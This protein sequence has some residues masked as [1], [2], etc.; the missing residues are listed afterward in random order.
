MQRNPVKSK[1]EKIFERNTKKEREK[2]F[3]KKPFNYI[4][5]QYRVYSV[6]R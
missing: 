3:F 6:Q 1:K 4:G 2:K 5:R